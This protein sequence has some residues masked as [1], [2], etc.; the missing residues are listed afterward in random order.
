MKT[1][2]LLPL[3]IEELQTGCFHLEK[4]TH[5]KRDGVVSKGQMDYEHILDWTTSN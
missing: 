1:S 4:K 2:E 5:V 3:C